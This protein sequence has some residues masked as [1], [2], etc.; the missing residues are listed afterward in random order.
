MSWPRVWPPARGPSRS[1]TAC[2]SISQVRTVCELAAGLA[3]GEG[4][5]QVRHSV[6]EYLTG[7]GGL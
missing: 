5:L 2:S 7:E 3:A 6:L 4:T 1:D